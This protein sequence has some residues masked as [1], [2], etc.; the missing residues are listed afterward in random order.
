MQQCEGAGQ[1]NLT[2]RFVFILHSHTLAGKALT[3]FLLLFV[4]ELRMCELC[5]ISDI[6][7]SNT[8]GTSGGFCVCD[9]LQILTKGMLSDGMVVSSPTPRLYCT[10]ARRGRKSN[11]R[12]WPHKFQIKFQIVINYLHLKFQLITDVAL[13][14]DVR[15]TFI[16]Q[17]IYINIYTHIHTHTRTYK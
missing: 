12:K 13:F 1:V 10:S 6:S 3:C 11:D 15:R 7:D 17:N 16:Y 4:T 5:G 2:E 8:V 9:F 14:L